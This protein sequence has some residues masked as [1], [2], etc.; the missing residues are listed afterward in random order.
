MLNIAR[1]LNAVT[2]APRAV[3]VPGRALIRKSQRS[4]MHLHTVIAS[5]AKAQITAQRQKLGLNMF[6]N[7]TRILTYT[8]S[9]DPDVQEKSR[10]GSSRTAAAIVIVARNTKRRGK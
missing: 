9:G 7:G 2:L 6:V 8:A 1:L 4:R 3:P 5:R 10:K